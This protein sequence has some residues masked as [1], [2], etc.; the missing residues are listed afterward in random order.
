MNQGVFDFFLSQ[1]VILGC[2]SSWAC[3]ALVPGAVP[4]TNVF[5]PFSF[6]FLYSPSFLTLCWFCGSDSFSKLMMS[7]EEVA[8]E[9]R[10]H[11]D[12][13]KKRCGFIMLVIESAAASCG[14]PSVS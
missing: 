3:C 4:A 12:E 14:I 2:N 11:R 10:F 5:L 8:G 9:Q 7:D 13:E 6:F 1:L